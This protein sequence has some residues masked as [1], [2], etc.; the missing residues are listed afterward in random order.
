MTY[1]DKFTTFIDNISE[2]TASVI[3]YL[4][5]VLTA[6]LGYEILAR[7]AF[8][9]PTKWAFDVSYMLGGTFFLFG[10]AYALKYQR[11]VRIDIFYCQFSPRMQA[12]IDVVFYLLF[13]S[14]CGSACSFTCTPM[15]CFPG[16]YR[17]AR[18]R[19]IGSRLSIRLKH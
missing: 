12:T 14:P 10:E 15:C 19:V 2:V 16:L 6:V 1:L 4:V 3:I 5:V 9:N 11:H 7:Y 18:C 8:N 17:N 13:F